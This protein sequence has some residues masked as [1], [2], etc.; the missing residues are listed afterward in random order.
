MTHHTIIQGD[1]RAGLLILPD[2]SVHC[3]VTSPPYFQQRDYGADGQ[4]GLEP[5]PADYIAA[6]VE[7]CR[8]VRRV[9]R[10]DGTFWLNV[11]DSHARKR[12]DDPLFGPIKEGDLIGI[13][14]MLAFA[15]RREGWYL[16]MDNIWAK[17]NPKPSSVKNR[18][19]ASHE[20]I[21]HLTKIPTGYFYDREA[22]LEPLKHPEA[23]GVLF[24]GKK[25][26]GNVPN[27][28]Y[29]GN[30]YDPSALG[31]RNKWSVWTMATASYAGNHTAVFPEALVRTCILA[32]T[33]AAGCCPACGA[34]YR[35]V[36][37]VGEANRAWQQACGGDK[38]GEYR[39]T[40]KKDYQKAQAEDASAI[41]ARILQG[42][43]TKRTVGWEPT[44]TCDA[45]DPV[46]CTV[47]DPFHGS[48]TV[49]IFCRDHGRSSVG[50]DLNPANIVEARN[51]LGLDGQALLDTGA[52][53]YEFLV[54]E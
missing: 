49:T 41:K 15:L 2:D 19:T 43:R 5:T 36:I 31:G 51:R 44:C 24:G 12:Y 1:A 52:V 26:P 29:S 45:G 27:A 54:V 34:P 39:G 9:I 6:L 14:W 53:E 4:I 11:G 10:P 20:Y 48:G 28:T 3:C 13:P 50:L 18:T 37:E 42:L 22:I 40:A 35:R 17:T 8:G 21:F 32:G 33:S 23:A 16:R 7:V 46:P 30:A 38:N 47:L 25:Y